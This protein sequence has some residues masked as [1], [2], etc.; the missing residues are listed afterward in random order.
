MQ[1]SLL[2][3]EFGDV[4]KYI[5]SEERRRVERAKVP[6]VLHLYEHLP[7]TQNKLLAK[8]GPK[9]VRRGGRGG[10]G[11]VYSHLRTCADITELV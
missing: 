11:S 10:L 7:Y 9:F 4:I 2:L 8:D 3:F 1:A 6:I 5:L